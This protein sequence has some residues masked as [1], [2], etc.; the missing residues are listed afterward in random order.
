VKIEEDDYLAH[1]GILR[2]S[3][4]YPWGSGPGTNTQSGRNKSFLDFVN[5]MKK[6][7]LSEAEIVA[8]LGGGD[9]DDQEKISIA[10][11]RAAKTYA[12]DQQKREQ[13]AFAEKLK[14]KGMSNPAIAERMGLQGESAVRAL[15]APGAK[16]KSETLIT[17]ANQLKE[18]VD[19]DT[20]VD[21]GSGAETW[22]N[23]SK[24]RLAAAAFVLAEQGYSTHVVNV[25]QIATGFDTKTKVL[26]PPG[27]T[28]KDAW[29]HR[30]EIKQI[31]TQTDDG[32][33][34][35][36]KEHPLVSIN[37]N[38]IKVRYA[39]E[40]GANSD[41]VIFLRPGK[42]DLSMGKANY[43][44]VRI[45]VGD[46][47]YLKG[48]AMYKD[49]LPPGTDILFN[50]NKSKKEYPNKLDTMKK[51]ADDQDLP[52]ESVTRPVVLDMGH[53]TK[54]RVKSAVNLV[55]EEGDWS[56]WSDT[57]SSQF[58]SKQAPPFVKQQLD[59]TYSRHE[60]EFNEIMKLTNPAVK[61]KLLEDFADS[62]DSAAGHLKAAALPRQT[63][64][65]ILPVES[66]KPTEIYAPG[67][68][69]GEKV[70]LVR[71][72]HGG[73]FEI[74][75]VTVN[76]RHPGARKLLGTDPVDAIGIH[77]SVAAKLSGADFDGDTVLV[78]PNGTGKIK[79]EA[80]L[81][82]LKNFDPM[83]YR[84]PDDVP[85]MK[86]STKQ[87]EMGKISN[88]I[89]D[90]T[91]RGAPNDE[92]ARAVR[93]SMVVID[94]EKHHLDYR[95]SAKENG[96]RGLQSVYQS[97]HKD[98]TRPGASTLISRKKQE[99]TRPELKGLPK[100]PQGAPVDRATGQ[101]Q[102]VETGRTRRNRDGSVS[103]VEG[104]YRKIDLTDDVHTLSSGTRVEEHYANYSNRQKAL[105]NRA[106][107]EA[108]KTPPT[109]WSS[110]AK[111][112]Y[113]SE[114]AS[115]NAKLTLAKKNRTLE[116]HAQVIANAAIQARKD[117]N[118]NLD[119][120]SLRKI[121]YQEQARARTRV[122]LDQTKIKF[123]EREWEAIQAGAIS[124]HALN[125]LLAKADM[126]I[127]RE[128]ATPRPKL[129]MSPAKTRQAES[130]AAAGYTRAEIANRLGVSLTTLG[131]SID[132]E[133]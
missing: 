81:A 14:A 95:R 100:F 68:N 117:A 17:I 27:V 101:K 110:S 73:K 102:L 57:L 43:A 12:R 125:Q 112:V 121:K 4:R 16:E 44:Q 15:L 89:T 25:P 133:G 64:K 50:T 79:A 103:L 87:I 99:V 70:V 104:K 116:R 39:E 21:I 107:V 92:L 119:G 48:M 88:L 42:D 93:H 69:N 96:I 34:T 108:F 52:F 35:F 76:N 38:R 115:L 47:H 82:G 90:M 113:K 9:G 109:V 60:R 66:I 54:E 37:P 29:Q 18:H 85:K 51:L 124:N 41:G 65:A 131:R 7:G 45:K 31:S 55:N 71:F 129:L 10:Q 80:S 32:G 1:Y 98:N 2:R 11:L 91:I 33:R 19:K 6:Q 114:V 105:A 36:A 127:V 13:I 106:R 74:P 30:F 86:S 77:P 5:E 83:T 3:G 78:I 40:G 122:K 75:E 53:P 72:P 97:E 22:L 118:P 49:D 46:G 94:A 63:W 8:G 58:L 20:Y 26:V 62:A 123:T 111:N 24:E 132:G 120:D 61:R 126:D 130:L 23:I 67:Y 56:N 84:L 128:F 59:L 28:Q